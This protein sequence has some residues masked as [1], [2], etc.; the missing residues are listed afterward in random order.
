IDYLR[1]QEARRATTAT[2]QT[3]PFQKGEDIQILEG[4][5]AGLKAVFQCSKARDRVQVLIH[6]LGAEKAV[7]LPA[8]Y[9]GSAV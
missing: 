3:E 1:Q 7:E 4:P 6:I 9:V 2:D 8:D 5:L